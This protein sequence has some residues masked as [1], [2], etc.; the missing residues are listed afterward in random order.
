MNEFYSR[1]IQLPLWTVE[2]KTFLVFFNGRANIDA[3][4][5]QKASALC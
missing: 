5:Y 3:R 1:N 2:R 4:P